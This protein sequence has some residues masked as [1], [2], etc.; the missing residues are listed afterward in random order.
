MIE[1]K[2]T[3]YERT[4]SQATRNKQLEKEVLRLTAEAARANAEADR[5]KVEADALRAETQRLGKEAQQ[6]TV[7]NKILMEHYLLSRQ[8]QFGTSSE[9]TPKGQE[10]L[11]NEAEA[12][13]SE[14]PAVQED[15]MSSETEVS[16]H[17]RRKAIGKREQD[18]SGLKVREI[19][20]E[21]QGADR[22]CPVCGEIMHEMS[23]SIRQEL[24]VIPA[25]LGLVKH[26][27]VIY[28]CR[29]CEHN[30]ITTPI[31]TAPRPKSAFPNSL[32]SPSAVA[33][34]MSQKYVECSPLY[35]LERYF[36]RLGF[37]L[38]RQ[39]QANWVIAGAVWLEFIYKRMHALLLE[40]D[41]AHADETEVQV[42]RESGRAA[43]TNSY[44]WLYRSG[45]DGPPICL[46]EYQRTRA[47][48]H[49]R[50]FLAEF[51]GYLHVDGYVGYIGL[52]WLI[53]IGC[54][55]HARRK[56]T[57]VIKLLPP[58]LQKNGTSPAHIGLRFC[59]KLFAIERDLKDATA[60]ERFA[61]RQARSRKVLDDYRAWLDV[62]AGQILRVGKLPEAITYSINQWSHLVAFLLDGRLEIDNNRAE[63]AIKPFVMGR[64]NWLFA[65][66]PKGAKSSA[67]VYSI[68]ET[69][70]ENGLNPQVYLKYL[71]EQ[72]PNI[73]VTDI[74]ALD[75]LL[76]W[77]PTVKANCAVPSKPIPLAIPPKRP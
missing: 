55:A 46:Y 76:P 59:N 12:C 19:R 17:T 32:A 51:K 5:L 9:K 28:G 1:I 21:L 50:R 42:L 37:D 64:K 65:T 14:V 68:V 29:P 40:R 67:I 23:Q 39:N 24:E 73:D 30:E 63:R 35:R 10:M 52:T 26:I 8:R 69:A 38:P 62:M 41:I 6:L 31:V 33:F 60:E 58:E 47:G 53:L 75:L 74:A 45:R 27:C 34:I 18:V 13:A 61:G 66:S 56:Y 49:P 72:L 7:N 71:F 11:F 54:W 70:K 43:Q 4:Q 44:M 57:D 2:H 15:L 22:L 36:K 48:E 77:A 25:S 20:H 16:A 3:T